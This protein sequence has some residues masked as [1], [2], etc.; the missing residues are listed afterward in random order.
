MGWKRNPA[1]WVNRQVNVRG[2]IVSYT[3]T[4][5]GLTNWQS[6]ALPDAVPIGYKQIPAGYRAVVVVAPDGTHV[7]AT[8]MP[9]LSLYFLVRL[10]PRLGPVT[11]WIT[12]LHSLPLFREIVPATLQLGRSSVYKVRFGSLCPG[13]TP[14]FCSGFAYDGVVIVS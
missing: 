1:A 11:H 4:R 10:Q 8:G 2:T 9:P 5:G 6:S 3:M 13:Q 14:I 7:S 12:A